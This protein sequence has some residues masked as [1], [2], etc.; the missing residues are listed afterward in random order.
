MDNWKPLQPTSVHAQPPAQHEHALDAYAPSPLATRPAPPAHPHRT[1]GNPLSAAAAKRRSLLPAWAGGGPK[2]ASQYAQAPTTLNAN[3]DNTQAASSASETSEWEPIIGIFPAKIHETIAQYLTISDLVN[4]A[5]VCRAIAR[6]ALHQGIWD[7]RAE[8]IGWQSVPGVAV[9]VYNS[10]G[11]DAGNRLSLSL[12]STTINDEKQQQNNNHSPPIDGSSHPQ[13]QRPLFSFRTENALPAPWNYPSY[14]SLKSYKIALRPF[15]DSLRSSIEAPEGSLLFTGPSAAKS[16]WGAYEQST[17]LGNLLRSIGPPPKGAGLLEFALA[18][19]AVIQDDE[20]DPLDQV[21]RSTISTLGI[22]IFDLFRYASDRR[23]DALKAANYGAS[24]TEEAVA[25]AQGDL[26]LFACAIWRLGQ[27]TSCLLRKPSDVVQDAPIDDNEP[28]GS[29]ADNR[30][31]SVGARAL[32]LWLKDRKSLVSSTLSDAAARPEDNMILPASGS[33]ASVALNFSPMDDMMASIVEEFRR[34]SEIIARIFPPEQDALLQ[35]TETAVTALLADYVTPL[36]ET[37]R[38]YSTHLYLRCCAASFT[39]SLRFAEALCEIKPPDSLPLPTAL[40]HDTSILQQ[41]D[42]MN[43]DWKRRFQ[44][45]YTESRCRNAVYQAW[46]GVINEYLSDECR[47]VRDEMAAVAHQWETDLENE[48]TASRGDAAFLT[49]KNPAAVKRS[50]LSGFKDVLLL[51]VTVV[52]RTAVHVGGAVFRTAGKGVSHLNPMKWQAGATT[53]PQADPEMPSSKE[54]QAPTQGKSTHN[55]SQA[56]KQANQ[57]YMDFSNG[58]PGDHTEV[59]SDDSELEDNAPAYNGV[60]LG[61]DW[62]VEVRAWK[63]V[64]NKANAQHAVKDPE[65][66]SDKAA[67]P[68]TPATPSALRPSTTATGRSTPTFSR[69]S[70]PLPKEEKTPPV[71]LQQMQLLLSLDIALQMIHLN[72]DSLKRVETFAAGQSSPPVQ[73]TVERIAFEFLGCLR[74][75]HVAPGFHQAIQQIQS[76]KPADHATEG[77]G[78]QDPKQPLVDP[79]VHFFELVHVGDTIAQIV[80]VYFDQELSRHVDRTDF[81]NAVVREKKR[82]ETGLDEAVAAGLNAG[83][84]LL[85]GQVEHTIATNQDP[86]DYYPESPEKMDLGSPTQACSRAITCLQLHCKLLTGCADRNVLEVFWQEIGLRLHSILCKHLKRQIISLD[87]GF[88]VIADLNAYHAFV[89]SLKQPPL[90][91]YFEALKML[92]NVYIIEDPREL[93]QLVRD[94]SI[95]RGTLTPDDVYEFLQARCDFKAIEKA[96]DK[97]MYGFKV[98]EDCVI[99]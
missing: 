43:E 10:P 2:R 54:K 52:P 60:G 96:V 88:K 78:E 57:G 21:L 35:W 19:S 27:D 99:T 44:L 76:W 39:Q 93:A 30:L 98:S 58:A 49:A 7:Q 50:V 59:D 12:N 9:T 8:L 23:S 83:V 28:S 70:T 51:P 16:S 47:W 89:S 20:S 95:F 45:T 40:S 68:R 24:G 56:T 41:G 31:Q 71:A 34:E 55:E 33:D 6:I 67:R 15:R 72:R 5:L 63:E 94:A 75:Q 48:A 13:G 29:A 42:H 87:G 97:E 85:M 22:Q 90:V 65:M 62:N 86:R 92:G 77:E 32:E 17:L 66:I 4:Y 80:Q 46:E 37:A 74:E 26:R 1:N 84:D 91:P 73:N 18:S 36:L 81:L 79:L 61:D 3:E 53:G 25:R 14:Q 64:A 69:S 82:F 11:Y 38:S